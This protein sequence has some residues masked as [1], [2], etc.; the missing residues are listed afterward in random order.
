MSVVGLAVLCCVGS[1]FGSSGLRF[2]LELDFWSGRSLWRSFLGLRGVGDFG[3]GQCLVTC[4]VWA[5]CGVVYGIRF[6]CGN[7]LVLLH[8][9]ACCVYFVFY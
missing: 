9:G 8:F 4:F 2:G 3:L 1:C 7:D 6:A 5:C